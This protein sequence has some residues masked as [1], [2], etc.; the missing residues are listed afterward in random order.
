MPTPPAMAAALGP[1]VDL[2]RAPAR[3]P[4]R[5]ACHF[6]NLTAIAD[7]MQLDREA[8]CPLASLPHEVKESSKHAL[9]LEAQGIQEARGERGHPPAP[10]ELRRS[11]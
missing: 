11:G 3:K 5:H 6:C 1:R 7:L 4:A 2:K 8:Y 9:C 10:R